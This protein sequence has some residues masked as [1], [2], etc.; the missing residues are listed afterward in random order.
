V[1]DRWPV[2][3]FFLLCSTSKISKTI[4]DCFSFFFS[5]PRHRRRLELIEEQH[6]LKALD[7]AEEEERLKQKMYIKEVCDWDD[8]TCSHALIP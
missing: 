4:R 6:K 8:D 2:F 7:Q 1:E 3:F 5:P